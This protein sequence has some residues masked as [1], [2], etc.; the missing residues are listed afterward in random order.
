MSV[1]NRN[2]KPTNQ[3][4]ENP[5]LSARRA[6]NEHV[7]AVVSSRQTWQV[8]GILSL[9]IAFASVGG[10][11]HIGS[12][13][14][15]IPYVIEIDKLGETVAI[16]PVQASDVADPRVVLAAVSNFITNARIVT[17]DIALQRKAIYAVYA[18]LSPK[19]PATVKMNEWMNGTEESSPFKRAE[20]EI[21]NTEIKTV[22]PQTS[23]TWQ[24]D[25][26]ETVRDRQGVVKEEKTMRALVTVYI[27]E[28]TSQ[29]TEEQLRMNPMS[30]YTRDFSWSQIQ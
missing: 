16:G 11:I 13:S 14:K 21:V 20:K 3:E 10:V 30:I 29:T 19:D 27:A 26:V 22:L 15:F 24:V 25:W 18:M 17:P 7:G 8:V 4:I 28:P 23:D 2:D 1:L 5:Y 6:W 9:L 12:Q